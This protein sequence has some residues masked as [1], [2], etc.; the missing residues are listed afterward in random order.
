MWR[1]TKQ[2]GVG[3]ITVSP[4]AKRYFNRILSS[5]R[6][7]YGKFTK[8]FETTIAKIHQVKYAVFCNSGTSA[9]QVALHALKQ[10]YRW[11][12]QDEI[13][14][15]ALTFVSTVNT[16][17]QNQLR[18]IFVDVEP[19][20]LM[21]D[22]AK[23]EAKIT[24][25]TKAVIPVHIGGQPADMAPIMRLAQKYHLRVIED[26]CETM[27]VKY[28]HKPVGSFGDIACFST[29]A[30]HTLVTGVGGFVCT[31]NPHLAVISKSLI[32]H[33]RDG[34]YLKIDDD[35]KKKASELHQVVK[36]RFNFVN[37]G[38]SF[39]LTEFEAALGLAQI[40]SW[41]DIIGKRRQNAACLTKGLSNLQN[42]LILPKARPKTEHG[43]MFYPI[44]IRDNRL[45]REDLVNFLEKNLIETRFLMPLLSQPVYRK[46]FGH[47]ASNYPVA[48]FL[49]KRGFYIG[50]QPQLSKRELDYVIAKFHDFFKRS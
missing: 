28:H 17:L 38:Y 26:S 34:I 24:A 15:P 8:G 13:I 14:V 1:P 47:L 36:R 33:G 2:L 37:L 23:I 43:F 35:C 12:D 44:I 3:D 40:K 41:R 9:L 18:P 46:L 7:T 27:F 5:G 10:Y 49:S 20:Y 42:F 19:D 16:V 6:I 4:L 48:T 25:R 30:A 22:P 29:Y 50:C 45:K 39:R 11:Q 31:N 32:N 21:L